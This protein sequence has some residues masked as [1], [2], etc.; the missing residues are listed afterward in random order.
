[1][2]TKTAI[3]HRA[4]K[5]EFCSVANVNQAEVKTKASASTGLPVLT[6]LLQINALEKDGTEV[7][8]LIKAVKNNFV[9]INRIPGAILS[10]IPSYWERQCIDTDGDLVALI[11]VCRSWRRLFLS[12]PSL[13]ARL[14]FTNVD[15]TKAYIKRSRPSPLE[16]TIFKNKEEF[17]LEDAFLLA[18]P[19]IK[20]FKS[21]TIVG[22]SDL[23]NLTRHLTLPAPSLEELTV[24]FS[25]NL[26][27]VLDNVLVNLGLL[28]LR[29]LILGGI[30]TYLPWRNLQNLTTFKLRCSQNN[31]ITV[32]QL[33]DFLEGS[34]QLRD[35][36]LCDSIPASSNAPVS[37]IVRLCCVKNLTIYGDLAH[38]ILL[39]HLSIPT[40]TSLVLD[41]NFRG[42]KSPL[43]AFLPRTNKNLKNL[44]CITTVNLYFG[45]GTRFVRLVGPG[46]ELYML[47]RWAPTPQIPLV[48]L[49]PH[50]LLSLSYFSLHM[51]RNLVVMEY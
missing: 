13:W 29:T 26:A 42:D 7:L 20:R 41:F 3:H 11:H 28:S 24:D 48:S 32:T 34:P 39:S 50:I 17:S 18:I 6:P 44:L 8:S 10:F 27:P 49:D 14:D 19:H 38:G 5:P 35:I 22:T 2:G 51:T 21:L 30:I 36:T 12:R 46:G 43:P 25:R 31:I 9:P 15:K 23:Q 33:L 16:V 1:M 47:G 37:R 45:E 4:L 40:R